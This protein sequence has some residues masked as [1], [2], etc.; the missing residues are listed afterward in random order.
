MS[1]ENISHA[2][3]A[4]SMRQ[5][6]LENLLFALA[7]DPGLDRTR[8]QHA[9]DEGAASLEARFAEAEIADAQLELLRESLAEIR[10]ALS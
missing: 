1:E 3:A 6:A 10:T 9:F 2:I 8:L 4:I 5:V 7:E